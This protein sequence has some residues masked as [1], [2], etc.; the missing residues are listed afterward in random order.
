MVPALSGSGRVALAAVALLLAVGT[1][2]ASPGCHG[3]H[4]RYLHV[5]EQAVTGSLFDEM[6]SCNGGDSGC[7]AAQVKPY[8]ASVRMRGNDWPYVGHTMVGH[9]RLRNIR[10]SIETVV[11]ESVPGNFVELGVWRGGSCIFAKAVLDTLQQHERKVVLFDAF[12][13]VPGYS[14]S[15][16]SFLKTKESTVRHNFAKYGLLDDR[17]QIVKGLFKDSLPAYSKS[18]NDPIAVLRVDGNFY[19]SYQ[20]AFYYLYERVPVGGFVIFDD[21]G[22][23]KHVQDFWAD[24]KA[25]YGISDELVK[26]DDH[27]AFFQKTQ[28]VTLDLSK[29]RPPRDAN[30]GR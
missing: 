21:I 27:A 6:G 26:I 18:N 23:H 16:G 3:W 14:S 5:I 11:A 29:M 30:L 24:F 8:N 12:D 20:D 25:D 28:A 1:A 9:L 19:D 2:A 13:L 17:V 15:T 4:N 10:R 7:D 22:S